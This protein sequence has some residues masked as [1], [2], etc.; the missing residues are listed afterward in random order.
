MKLLLLLLHQYALP[1]FARHC[2]VSDKRCKQ[3]CDGHILVQLTF[4][5]PGHLGSFI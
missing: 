2:D 4:T 5:V 3:C 1:S